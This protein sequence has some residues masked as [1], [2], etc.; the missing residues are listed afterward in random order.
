VGLL[1]HHVQRLF[2]EFL[3]LGPRDQ[4]RG[5]DGERQT[6]EFATPGEVRDRLAGTPACSERL[7]RR[8][9]MR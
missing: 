8:L 3:G 2:N 6:P 4:H 5:I 1:A 9:L 7:E